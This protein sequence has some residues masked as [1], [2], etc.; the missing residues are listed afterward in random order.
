MARTGPCLS[1]RHTGTLLYMETVNEPARLAEVL[2]G[3]HYPAQKWEVIACAEIWG[4]DLETR[5][6]LYGLPVRSFGNLR[7]V[8][9]SLA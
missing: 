7:E 5:R 6:K 1:V 3:L 2:A 9:D 8:V 4:V